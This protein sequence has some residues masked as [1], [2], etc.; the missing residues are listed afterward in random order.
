MN[1][2]N[3]DESIKK[4]I[5]AVCNMQVHTQTNIKEE[6]KVN[7]LR[8]IFFFMFK[9]SQ[10]SITHV[11]RTLAMAIKQGNEN[12][13]LWSL[14]VVYHDNL[15]ASGTNYLPRMLRKNSCEQS[16]SVV[17]QS[18]NTN[19]IFLHWRKQ[20]HQIQIQVNVLQTM[21]DNKKNWCTQI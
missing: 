14:Y 5:E 12:L 9:N 20:H 2:K 8:K 15:S 4:W 16:F 10:N 3:D 11:K 17:R 1:Q 13:I 7:I 6:A 21:N 19:C 18:K